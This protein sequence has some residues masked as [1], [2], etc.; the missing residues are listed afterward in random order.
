MAR[1]SGMKANGGL[2][3]TST[4]KKD[5]KRYVEKQSMDVIYTVIGNGPADTPASIMQTA[6]IPQIGQKAYGLTVMKADAQ[7]EKYWVF[8]ADYGKWTVTLNLEALEDEEEEEEKDPTEYPPD[9]SWD[10]EEYEEVLRHDIND[11]TKKVQTKCGEPLT[12]TTRRVVPVLT[13]KRTEKAPFSPL[14]ILQYT[15]AVNSSSFWGAPAGSA[16]LCKIGAQY[17]QIEDKDGNK[18]W[19]VD[20][21]YVVKFKYDPE[22]DAPW[23]ARILHWGTKAFNDETH[24]AQAVRDGSGNVTG[25]L[26]D[27]RGHKLADGAAPV[28]LEFDVYKERDF[29]PLKIDEDDISSVWV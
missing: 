27:A 10:S 26:L 21:T 1:I 5:G 28:Y 29:S 20:V 23:Q 25:T 6:G 19:Y 11:H 14:T 24:E 4:L 2:R 22:T 12:L 17:K 3:G 16:L 9:V 7:R 15:N 13:I 8:G 18:K